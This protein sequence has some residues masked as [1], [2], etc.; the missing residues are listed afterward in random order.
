[1]VWIPGSRFQRSPNDGESYSAG[2]GTATAL[3]LARTRPRASLAGA[4]SAR[5]DAAGFP[6]SAGVLI[7]ENSRFRDPQGRERP[8]GPRHPAFVHYKDGARDSRHCRNHPVEPGHPAVECRTRSELL[9]DVDGSVNA[10]A[11]NL[12]YYY[13][14]RD[15]GGPPVGTNFV[16]YRSGPG[17]QITGRRSGPGLPDR[18]RTSLPD[19]PPLFAACFRTCR[20][21]RI[22]SCHRSPHRAA[23]SA[24]RPHA[25][26]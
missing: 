4:G 9:Q 21:Y 16:S 13:G 12:Q 26:R 10:I 18:F 8:T 2:S 15:G 11:A 7:F 3:G 19:Q 20:R 5:R 17:V 1:M 23:H 25:T 24:C 6:A 22:Y 14:N